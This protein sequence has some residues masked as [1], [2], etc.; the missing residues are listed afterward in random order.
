MSLLGSSRRG[1]GILLTDSLLVSAGS[2]PCT[3]QFQFDNKKNAMSSSIEL[4]YRIRVIP[5]PPETVLQGRQRRA[6]ACLAILEND[7]RAWQSRGNVAERD[8]STLSQEV[9]RLEQEVEATNKALRLA[10]EQEWRAK[11]EVEEEKKGPEDW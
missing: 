9:E 10:R 11:I 3:L 2:T 1:G 6:Q 8:L 4:G 7:L 5:P